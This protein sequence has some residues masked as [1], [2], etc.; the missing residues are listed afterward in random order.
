MKNKSIIS[1]AKKM[2]IACGILAAS[3]SFGAS[4]FAFSDLKGNPAEGKINSLH[5]KG[6]I[7]GMS[8]GK[9]APKFKLTF[10]QAVQVIVSGLELKGQLSNSKASDFFDNV[11]DKSWFAPAFLIAQQNGLT[12]DR[13]VNPNGTI[14]RAQFAHLLTQG[15][16][17]KGNFPVTR[18]YFEISDGDKLPAEVNNSLQTLLNTRIIS[19]E[20]GSKFRPNDAITRAEAA[21]W[22]YDAAEF[23]KRVITP[24]NQTPA[25]VYEKAEVAVVKA[26]D[27]VNKVSLTVNN[28]PNLGYGLMI[29]KIEFN[30]DMTAVIYYTVTQPDPNKMYPQVISK[31]TIVTYLSDVYKPVAQ[32]VP[33]APA[34]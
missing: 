21:I 26:A 5:E 24:A 14:T 31:A 4:A 25:P 15:L 28:L 11:K 3:V 23:A 27:G 20:A 10:G 17:S 19:L 32:L 33:A 8:N 2:T 16:L 30:K 1:H 22:I 7:N 6:I 18:M 13:N 12:V 9:F 29:Q 34:K